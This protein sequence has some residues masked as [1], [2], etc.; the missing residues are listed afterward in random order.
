MST[1]SEHTCV[2]SFKAV[3]MFPLMESQS[4][5]HDFHTK[6]IYNYHQKLSLAWFNLFYLSNVIFERLQVG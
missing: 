6:I 4:V 2:G 1:H 5:Q 3:D